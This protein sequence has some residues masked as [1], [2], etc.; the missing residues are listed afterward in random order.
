MSVSSTVVLRN[1]GTIEWSEETGALLVVE[2]VSDGWTIEVDQLGAG[3]LVAPGQTHAFP[4]RLRAPSSDGQPDVLGGEIRARMDWIGD[5]LFGELHRVK[6]SVTTLKWPVIDTQ[7][8]AVWVPPGRRTTLSVRASG[9]EPLRY[10]WFRNGVVISDGDLYSGSR[11]PV[12]TITA[13]EAEVAAEYLCEVSNDAGSV[14]SIPMALVVGTAPPRGSGDR[15]RPDG[16]SVDP[17]TR[18]GGARKSGALGSW[19][20]P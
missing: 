11:S 17:R 14:I 3:D 5:D 16:A 10:R 9:T 18:L 15:V 20:Y 4:V 6:V 13:D 19:E 12:L 1:T 2:S 7:S 8:D